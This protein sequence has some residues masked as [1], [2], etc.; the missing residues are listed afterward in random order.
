MLQSLELSFPTSDREAVRTEGEIGAPSRR[1]EVLRGISRALER[2]DAD[3]IAGGAQ[4]G[5]PGRGSNSA[6]EPF[7]RVSG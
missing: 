5:I 6:L 3:A 1:I 7:P 4:A 2:I